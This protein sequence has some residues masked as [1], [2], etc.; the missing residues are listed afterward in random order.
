MALITERADAETANAPRELLPAL[1]HGWA[2]QCPCCGSGA[3]FESYLQVRPTCPVCGEELHHHRAD[4][5]PAWLTMIVTG[6]VLAF[7]L[8]ALENAASPPMWVHWTLWPV[9]VVG[10]SLW[11]LPRIKGAV[12]GMQWAWRMHGFGTDADAEG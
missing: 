10:L 4:D 11:L 5:L 8:L 7:G 2:Q 9:V 3:L 1:A 6:H 12:V